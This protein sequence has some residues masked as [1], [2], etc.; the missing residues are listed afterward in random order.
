MS[1]MFMHGLL[2]LRS[3]PLLQ[4][5]DKPSLLAIQNAV[6]DI[7][8]PYC[9]P[10][11]LL[12]QCLTWSITHD[13]IMNVTATE[14]V[15]S[16]SSLLQQ[17]V[18]DIVEYN[19]EHL[20]RPMA[21][22]HFLSFVSNRM[23]E[24]IIWGFGGS[25]VGT[26][27]IEF[28]EIIRAATSFALPS[29]GI[30]LLDH[31][32]NLAD[33]QWRLWSERVP[34]IE[35]D[36]KSVLD[37]SVVIP[38]VDTLRNQ[39]IM[40]AFLNTRK[41]VILCGPPGSGK[42]MTL[43]DTL[44]NLNGF[45]VVSVNFSSTTSP[46]LIMKIFD[47]YGV[48]QKT[49][50]G[51]VLR[52]ASPEKWLI[53][54]CDEVNLPE[55][56]KYGT[57][58][59]IS[60]LRQLVEQQGFWSTRD[61]LWVHCE[62][63]QFVAACNPPTDPGRVPL[64]TRFLSHTPLLYV[65]YP[66]QQSLLQI[67]STFNKA[68]VSTK[69][70]IVSQYQA[71]TQ[72]MVDFYEQNK[73]RFSLEQQ[74]QYVYSPRELS[75]WVR[76]LHNAFEDVSDVTPDE[77]IIFDSLVVKA[78][79]F[80][81]KRFFYSQKRIEKETRVKRTRYEAIIKKFEEMGFLQTYVDKMPNSEGQIRYFYVNFPKLAEE[82]VL[83]KL[84]REKSTLFGAM[85]AYMEYHA[86]EEFKALCPS[87]VKEK[88]KKNQEE[89]RIEEIRVMLEETLNERREMYNNG[90]LDIKPT[91]KLHPTTVVLTNQQKQGFLDLETRYG[92]ESIHQAFIAYCD[93]VLE[94]VCKP[95]NLFNYFLT[96]D[97][98]HHDYSIFINSLNSYMIKYSSPLK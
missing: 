62:N 19:M 94:K 21:G 67:Y 61:H 6:A 20:E 38:T 80:H 56:D 14:L 76:A 98:F 63:I 43:T 24:A 8:T 66:E 51:L 3:D 17:I 92:F 31:Y 90:K 74:P 18:M 2:C 78:I 57:Q 87:A 88:P 10:H 68:L 72:V 70:S 30:P 55:E 13:H 39:H 52:P 11:C 53:I 42:T 97:R 64:S 71:L 37:T 93:E 91:R 15:S 28:C 48:Y 12:E 86:D 81:Y 69:P 4:D 40:R 45:D 58:R 77:L 49:P 82:E 85:R 65:D 54:F 36:P 73:R 7:V 5:V 83:G 50:S 27:R 59:V 96:R 1:S 26:D 46:S 9:E 89:K 84:V 41:P 29:D 33:G 25:L 23:I 60:L 95:K 35:I 34:H 32:V 44:K 75:R 16:F 79:S 47:Q 22:E